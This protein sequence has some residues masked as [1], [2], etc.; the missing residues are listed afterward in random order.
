[1]SKEF[2]VLESVF[3][4]NNAIVSI[5]KASSMNALPESLNLEDFEEAGF[6][7]YQ[8]IAEVF[9]SSNKRQ[10][11]IN[12]LDQ[13][14][15]ERFIVS[16]LE[17][18]VYKGLLE[19]LRSSGRMEIPPHTLEE[20]KK[21]Q[22]REDTYRSRVKYL[23]KLLPIL[24][25]NSMFY[26]L[27][28]THL[29]YIDKKF[30]TS[31][32]EIR[33]PISEETNYEL[34]ELINYIGDRLDH[35]SKDQPPYYLNILFDNM[36]T[37][38]LDFIHNFASIYNRVKQLSTNTGRARTVI[39]MLDEPDASFHPEWS[40]RYIHYLIK[41]ISL[42]GLPYGTQFQIILATHSPFIVSDIPKE[43]IT[44]IN[45]TEDL[46]RIV[47]KADFGLMGNLYDIVKNDFFLDSPVGE[48]AKH[49]FT[50]TVER[51]NAWKEYD[52]KEIDRID[53]LIK[54]ID[55]P[56][57]RYRLQECLNDKRIKLRVK[58]EVFGNQDELDIKISA[59]EREL[60]ELK[61]RRRGNR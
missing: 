61:E 34:L 57:I 60:Q 41:C 1:M 33:V 13:S 46:R 5:R 44:C 32:F 17:V 45:V 28:Y 12:G 53:S 43:H 24:N 25:E 11:K 40:R 29:D 15:K 3:T 35:K 42:A 55:E 20:L 30:Y 59:M 10:N 54:S 19:Y 50:A 18:I 47:K 37:G 16:Y 6:Q 4:M 36:S 23:I 22:F 7:L 9:L 27:M 58:Q 49:F 21:I 51:I 31:N 52:E 8:G 56:V 39:L 38:E 26:E 48:F 14:H 2:T